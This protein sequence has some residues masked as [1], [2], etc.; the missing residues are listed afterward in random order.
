MRKPF[1]LL[2]AALA[3]VAPQA[4]R[5]QCTG[6]PGANLL[7]ASPSGVAGTFR[8]RALVAADLGSIPGLSAIASLTPSD[9]NFIVGNGSQWVA[10][11]GS[12]A[13]TSLGYTA[14][15]VLTK[16]LTVDGS[17]SGLDADLW[18]GVTPGTGVLT[19]LAL[20]AAEAYDPT[21][22]NGD[23]GIATKNDVRDKIESISTFTVTSQA[24]AEAGSNNTEGMTPLRS[25][26]HVEAWLDRVGLSGNRTTVPATDV[27]SEFGANWFSN[28]LL[29][30]TTTGASSS[31]AHFAFSVRHEAA[32]LST[33]GSTHTNGAAYF[34]SEKTSYPSTTETG[35]QDG[36]YVV[37][38]QGSEG[39]SCGICVNVRKVQDTVYGQTG[40][41]ALVKDINSS[42]TVL[43]EIKV[44]MGGNLPAADLRGSGFGYMT[45]L[46]DN[47]TTNNVI[48]N[49]YLVIGDINATD[50]ADSGFEVAFNAA[51][52]T[53]DADRYFTVTGD[54]HA[55]GMGRVWATGSTAFP[56]F[57]FISDTD[58]GMY[59]GGANTLAWG[60][61]GMT[62]M[63]LVNRALTL[64]KD[65]SGNGSFV[66]V[67]EY[68]DDAVT[69]PSAPGTDGVRIYA[70]ESGAK[71]QLCAL[72]ATGAAQCFATEP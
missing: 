36:L 24:T 34:E 63:T 19:T 25:E 66:G 2:A 9:N 46:G 54:Q 45:R 67:F 35:Q 43:R 10:E 69:A 56:A 59:S 11:S 29:V 5:A 20:P 23:D 61:G 37:V 4:A 31:N 27:G 49:G 15:D 8:A 64:P 28:N 51:S 33:T 44:T 48:A 41:E 7:C 16:L 3:L 58:T 40:V 18:R 6:Q 14:A 47:L 62:L 57:S 72:F 65:G 1:L 68:A 38:Q 53:A 71:T 13:Q 32:G 17:S 39:D 42:S 12:T 55:D 70:R 60:G 52:G 50:D 30:T 26:Q 22:W 21:G